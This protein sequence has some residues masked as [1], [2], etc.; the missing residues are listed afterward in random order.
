M[1]LFHGSNII[2]LDELK[3]HL[4]DHN[5]PYI[6]LSTI[7]VVAGFYIA[8]AVERPYYWFP[9][10]FDKDGI[11]VYFELYP[12]ALREVSEGKMGSIYEVEADEKDVLPFKNIP[13]ARLG[14]VPMKVI[15]YTKVSNA[16]EWFMNEE[17]ENRLRVVRYGTM[18]KKQMNNWYRMI[19]DYIKSKDMIKTPECSY[20]KFVQWKFPHV[21]EQYEENNDRYVDID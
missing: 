12:N 21:W 10:G 18:N 9:Y 7:K 6:Y 14:T 1:R 5:R 19:F 20:A 4:A 8:N 2:G 17:L 11:P 16:Y 3:P 15:D 13:C